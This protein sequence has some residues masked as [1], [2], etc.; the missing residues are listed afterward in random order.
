MARRD[1]G[2]RAALDRHKGK[3]HKLEHQKRLRKQA[4]KKKQPHSEADDADVD[5]DQE[6]EDESLE[7]TLPVKM[8]AKVKS[9]KSDPIARIRATLKELT[10]KEEGED[11]DE[12]AEEDWATEDE[13]ESEEEAVEVCTMRTG[14]NNANP[15]MQFDTT[16]PEGDE[17]DSSGDE[18]EPEDTRQPSKIT[19]PASNAQRASSGDS[20]DKDSES[21]VALSDL[22]SPASG[23]ED[24]IP[25]RRLTINN[26][27][28]LTRSLE[29]FALPLGSLPF[30]AHQ[31]ITTAEP[32]AISDV[33]DDLAREQAFCKQALDAVDSAKRLLQQEGVPFSRPAD[34]FA[35]MVKTDEHMGKVKGRL[36][37]EAASKKASA[38]AKKQRDLKKF[39]KQVQQEKLKERAKAKKDMLERVSVLKRKRQGAGLETEG[40][41]SMF[42][43]ALEDAATTE[44]KDKE[45]R[46]SRGPGGAPNAKRQKKDAKFGF[47]GK[48]RFAKSGDAIS[49]SDMSG[50]STKRMKGQKKGPQRP[51]KSKRAKTKP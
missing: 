28:A 18:E 30:S 31:S 22:P 29:S 47:G 27:A 3:D 16:L 40:E 39:G 4:G 7:V 38:D 34:Y 20:D 6:S 23:D 21:D 17:S 14:N 51:G 9:A 44:R 36:I 24:I 1:N 32:V 5:I 15:G 42:D 11:E 43:V 19:I 8:T 37:E 50:F 33:E 49:S 13:D 25:H 2:L 45:A 48:K 10:G 41:E 26:T 12:P 35:E 46:R